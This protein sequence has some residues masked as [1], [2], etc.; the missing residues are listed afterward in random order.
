ME[1]SIYDLIR[2]GSFECSCGK[3]HRAALEELIIEAGALKKLPGLIKSRGHHKAFILTDQN[4]YEAAGRQVCSLLDNAGIPYSIYVFPQRELEPDEYAVG[5][6]AMHFDE[7]CDLILAVGS[8]V[9]ND[10]AKIL[11]N[12]TKRAYFIAATAPSMDGYASATSS[13]A[14]DGVKVSLNSVCPSVI[15]ADLDVLCNAPLISLQ[16]GM[17]DMVAKYISICE[18]RIAQL[19]I[20]ESYCPEIADMVRFAVNKC[21]TNAEGLAKRD[22]VAVAAVMEGLVVT[23][24]A[25]SYAG[26]SRPASG[27]EHYFSHV[28]DMRTLE[29][30]T[31][32]STHG[33]QCG[34]GTL[35]SIGIY[36]YIRK[37]TPD[38][39][40]ALAHAQGFNPDAWNE[41]LAKFLGKGAVTM[42]RDEKR[43]GKY[44]LMKHAARL[45]KI[46]DHWPQ[47]LQIIDEEI[48]ARSVVEKA[49]QAIGAP[50]E[51]AQIGI[52][53]ETLRT[54]F[55]MT[56]DIRDKY[57][58]SRL[59]WDLGA[60]DDA[61]AT[62]F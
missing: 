15:I 35:L 54:T 48:P 3:Y 52:D 56:K 10:T 6:A 20:G 34:V 24:I 23:G 59:L 57:I 44:D 17:G 51:P 46:I 33:I 50:T 30:G 32:G 13:M 29:F 21:V 27:M 2:A 49:L 38:K 41:E 28:W 39:D 22:P 8:G 31:S 60:I 45:E 40:R 26:I 4:E 37:L 25:M 55:T 16:S 14:R 53:Q 19:L 11:T 36:D 62:L 1:G 12:L 5:A 42:I 9:I 58:G 61:A 18:W 47:I 43:E 7:S